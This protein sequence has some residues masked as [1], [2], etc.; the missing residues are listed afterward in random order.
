M[1]PEEILRLARTA[2]DSSPTRFY[3]AAV[4]LQDYRAWRAR[5]GIEPLDGD[6]RA[7]AM[8]QEMQA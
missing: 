1:D 6:Q 7:Q 4:A 3:D 8:E 2:L 5:G